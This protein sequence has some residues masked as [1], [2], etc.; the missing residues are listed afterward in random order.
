MSAVIFLGLFVYLWRGIEPHLLYYG[1]GVFT[2]YPIVIWEGAFVRATFSTPGGPARALAALLAQSYCQSWLG[3]LTVAAILG[4][5]F[6]GVQR[7]LRSRQ[8]GRFRD[9]AWIP[10]LLAL[11]IYSDYYEDPLPILLTVGLSV[12]TAILHDALGTRTARGR[13]GL[14]LVL[15]GVLYYLAG[16]A[17][18]VFAAIVCLTE[19]L[20]HRR[21]I[22]ALVQVMLAVA[23]VFVLGRFVFGLGPQA[24]YAAGTPWDL[25]KPLKFFPVA[26]WLALALHFFVP[27]LILVA[28]G[29]EALLAA[30]ARRSS[31]RSRG[32]RGRQPVHEARR[33]QEEKG[34]FY[35]FTWHRRAS[36]GPQEKVECP[37]FPRRLAGAW[38]RVALRMFVVAVTA[39]LCLM[40]S[41]TQAHE[42]RALHYY[43][44]QRDWDSVLALAHRMRSQHQFTR[45]GVFDI[46]RALA[47]TGRLGDELFAFP[48][49]DLKTLYMR[50][51]DMSGR[52]TRAKSL[53]LYLDLGC[54]N[55]AQENAYELLA[56][57]GPSPPVLEALVRIHLAK[58]EYEP[59]RV[60]LAALREYAGSGPY[61]RRWQAIVADPT[62]AE[63]DPLLESWRKVRPTR[64]DT[65]LGISP[66]ALRSLLEDKPDHRLAFEYLMACI[67]LRNERA[68]LIRRL[69]L[70]KPLGYPQLPR[71]YAEALLVQ[72]LKTGRPAETYG[73]TIGPDVQRQFEEIRRIVTQSRGNDRM[74]FDI[75]AP[76]CGDTYMF[77]SMFN[78]CGLK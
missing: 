14:F 41:R 35:F 60:F 10:L 31:W 3:A 19:A 17:A 51:D 12:W 32:K 39:G 42:E 13:A 67:L 30:D 76:Q 18:L 15:L 1:F 25:D 22:L 40:V 44:Q 34:T 77:Y 47:H 9:L 56:H 7:L 58:G 73:W 61:V 65:S 23:G 78:L 4:V 57:E 45:S 2:A 48:Q 63:T 20:L 5:L 49:D 74:L 33:W 6:V 68:E 11:M 70:L 52:L 29:G 21:I 69:P 24:A 66:V 53:E 16:A 54:L 50:F 38:A 59:A 46:D 43:A 37:L 72:S 64:D 71:H 62:R 26:N 28:L 75:L 36:A 55:A 27:G 8:A